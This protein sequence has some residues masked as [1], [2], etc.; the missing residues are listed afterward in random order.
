[1]ARK[2]Y[3]DTRSH[4]IGEY[5][6]SQRFLKNGTTYTRLMLEVRQE[7]GK[8]YLINN[9][10]KEYRMIDGMFKASHLK[11]FVR[12]GMLPHKK[13]VKPLPIH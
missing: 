2:I 1:M 4:H 5:L 9:A 13:L 8:I 6:E 3:F 10:R 12:T 7:N 11:E